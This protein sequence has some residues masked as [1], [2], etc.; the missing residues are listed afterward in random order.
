M[1]TCSSNLNTVHSRDL[2]APLCP[3]Q[4][5]RRMERVAKPILSRSLI[6]DSVVERTIPETI[7]RKANKLHDLRHT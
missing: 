4:D 1:G 7:E 6:A 5:A 2:L 3:G